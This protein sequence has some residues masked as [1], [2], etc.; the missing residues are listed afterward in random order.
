MQEYEAVIGMEL[1]V[2]LK[3][4]TKLFCSCPVESES[5]ANTLVCPICAGFPG[6]LPVLNEEAVKLAVRTALTLGCK[7]NK[8]SVFS[9]KNYFYPD[10][11]KGYQ[12]TQ[13]EHPLAEEG[14][15]IIGNRNIRIRRV[16][17]EEDSG[18][19]IHTEDTTFVDLN[20]AG[21]PLV[22]IVTEPDIHSPKEAYS[23]IT[24][25]REI[26]RYIGVSNADMEK[27]ELRCEPNVSVHRKGEPLGT[28]REIK[29]LNSIRQVE[30]GIKYEI[31]QQINSLKKGRP[32]ERVTLLWDEKQKVTKV[33]RK[34]ETEE[35]YRYFD[36]PD[37]PP[38]C[39]SDSFLKEQWN[40][41]GE[42]PD[43]RRERMRKQYRLTQND[44]DTL[45]SR[46][47]LADYFED[48][49]KIT[50]DTRLTA[51]FILVELLG[52]LNENSIRIEDNPISHTNLSELISLMKKGVI[53]RT[54]A[55]N[56]LPKIIKGQSPMKVVKQLGLEKMEEK[57]EMEKIVQGI[58]NK[59][60]DEVKR[61]KEG[62]SGLFGFFVGEVMKAT[63]GKANPNI[64]GE[65]LK[66]R[67]SKI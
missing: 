34:K 52:F 54:V 13:Y 3:T 40:C 12:I 5:E 36:E 47:L 56:I 32:V 51:G 30:D 20:R 16:H 63:R 46:K 41:I 64:V 66:E 62:K 8:M 29:N 67:L 48:V 4:M 60:P 15:L 10:L 42:L 58:L 38:L 33:M 28:R 31:E 2:Q 23:Y 44:A 59:Y 25:L 6:T 17:L 45:V 57:E 39:I 21:V 61:Y 26:L 18:K 11:P 43:E 22:E 35:D 53:T 37:L 27:G 65:L 19:L 50:K 9:R 49:T 14:K 7:V 1:H 55:R 24:K